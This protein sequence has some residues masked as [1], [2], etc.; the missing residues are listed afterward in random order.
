MRVDIKLNPHLSIWGEEQKMGERSLHI[1]PVGKNDQNL[2][3]NIR[4]KACGGHTFCFHEGLS[5]GR[6]CKLK[7]VDAG[8]AF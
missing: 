2:M 7:R 5:W 1:G 6:A 4:E 3:E 8:L